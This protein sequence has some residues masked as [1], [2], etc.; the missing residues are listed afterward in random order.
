[1][2]RTTAL[3]SSRYMARPT[4]RRSLNLA[5]IT[6]GSDVTQPP[7]PPPPPPPQQQQQQP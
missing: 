4:F 3:V 2:M 5:L 1:M 7:P 6:T